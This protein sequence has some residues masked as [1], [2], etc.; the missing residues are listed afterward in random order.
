MNKYRT[1]PR[2]PE[3]ATRAVYEVVYVTL[4]SNRA[5]VLPKPNAD[6][7]YVRHLGLDKRYL[8]PRAGHWIE[9]NEETAMQRPEGL[10]R[11]R[12]SHSAA[13]P[14]RQSL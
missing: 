4:S 1:K 8:V 14:Y 12:P 13:R 3:S 5:P 2:K 7:A 10:R 9:V 11:A 6:I